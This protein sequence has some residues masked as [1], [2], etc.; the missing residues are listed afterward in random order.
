M[1]GQR[2]RCWVLP[3]SV[4]V[5]AQPAASSWLRCWQPHLA[6]PGCWQPQTANSLLHPLGSAAM[7]S[8]LTHTHTQDPT[9][10]LSP[11]SPC[12]LL[13]SCRPTEAS[14][15]PP[16]RP[17]APHTTPPTGLR[18]AE[19]QAW[20]AQLAA[21]PAV[22]LIASLDHVHAGLLWDGRGAAAFRW[23]W[24]DATSYGPYSAET[25]GTAP[26]L[27]R[28][29]GLEGGA[30]GAGTGGWCCVCVVGGWGESRVCWHVRRAWAKGARGWLCVC[31]EGTG[32][33]CVVG[34]GWGEGSGE[35]S[36]HGAHTGKRDAAC[37]YCRNCPCRWLNQG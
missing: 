20:L 10:H 25:L 36:C 32:L 35:T 6:T 30:G 9:L 2:C 34:G 37:A 4:A 21:L 13:Y 3:T 5:R 18:S 29:A 27:A 24:V 15:L 23:L 26:V 8:L 31:P 7:Y 1:L 16:P 28:E 14:R 17:L 22:H 12:L 19:D 11:S 33:V